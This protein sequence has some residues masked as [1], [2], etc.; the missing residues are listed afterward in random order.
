MSEYGYGRWDLVFWNAVLFGLF[1][2]TIPFK[3]KTGRRSASIYAAFVVA[4]YS[5]MYGFP[6]TIYILAWWSGY[7]NPLTHM[8]GHIF[9]P[10]IG[11]DIFFLFLHPLSEVM[12]IAGALMVAVGWW[13]VH[14]A[15]G[16]LAIDGLYGL[17]RHPQYSGI[18]LITTGMLVQ[19]AT[20]PTL[21]MW[22][23]LA[24]L[25]YR[26]AKEEER[27]MERRFGEHYRKYKRRVPM[28]TPLF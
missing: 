27:E 4:L 28:L 1:T 12:M 13:Q 15:K 5:E 14:G 23:V 22:P 10:I 16:E 6:L 18:L 19:W 11:E 25:Y 26:L 17:V 8:S 9:A 20:L 7:Q 3:R 2:L 24:V 21:L